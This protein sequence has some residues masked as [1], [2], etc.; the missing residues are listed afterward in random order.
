MTT[1]I[2]AS[3]TRR[4]GGALVALAL[5][6][7]LAGYAQAAP[8][9]FEFTGSV[10]L[11]DFDT[12]P[13]G[14]AVTGSYTFDDGLVDTHPSEFN[15][16]YGPVDLEIHF[17]GGSSV[18][19]STG[20]FFINN[21]SSGFGTVDEY[22]V[23]I[24]ST[25]DLTGSFAGLEWEFGRLYRADNT[26]VAF[27]DDSLPLTPPDLASLPENASFVELVGMRRPEFVGFNLTS[28]TLATSDTLTLAAA[29]DSFLRKGN[30]DRNEGANPGLR[31]QAAGDN[32]V[33][34]AF[35]PEAIDAFGDATSATLVLTIAE[36]ANNWGPNNNRTVD[37]HPLAVDF[38]EGDGQNAE[39]PGSQS[40]RGSGPGVTWNCAEDAE[41]ANQQT[42]CAS[43][44]DGGTFGPTAPSVLHVNG[45]SG[46]VSWV[47]TDDVAGGAT[48][49]LLKKTDERQPGRVSYHSKESAAAAGNPDLAPRLILE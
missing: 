27:S 29:K 42:D 47:V 20:E 10:T 36:I 32:R 48:A 12:I 18:V 26:G 9:T 8:L 34:V 11:S 28:L 44:W 39:V 14:S 17:V 7:T 46:A 2:T 5:G 23:R 16:I 22:S 24:S 6:L 4:R 35:D 1:S 37:A 49:W 3:T 19:T 41:I 38:A 43:R 25:P 13:V 31:L 33:V 40:T 45:L 15:G 30:P 21:N